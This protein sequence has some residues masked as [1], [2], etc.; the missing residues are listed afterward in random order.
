MTTSTALTEQ[1]ARS[2]RRPRRTDGPPPEEGSPVGVITIPKIGLQAVIVEGIDRADLKKG[3]G[4]YPGTPL[5]GQAGNAAIAGHRTTYGA[6]FNRIDEL[7]PGDEIERHHAAGQLPVPGPSRAGGVDGSPP[8][9][10]QA[11]W[12][13]KPSQT[14]V[15]D[16]STENLLTLTACHPKYSASER[17]I[18]QAEL[19]TPTAAAAPKPRSPTVETACPAAPLDQGLGGDSSALPVAL[20]FLAGA[21]AIGALAWFIG[22]RWKRWPVY[23]VATPLILVCV[24]S[25]TSTSTA[26]SRRCDRA[27]VSRPS[28]RGRQVAW[29]S[30]DRRWPAACVGD[31]SSHARA[32]TRPRR[33]PTTSTSTSTTAAPGVPDG[34]VATPMKALTVGQCFVIPIDDAPADGRAVWVVD[35]AQPH[36]HEIYDIVDYAG[37]TVKGDD[38]PG[39]DGGTGLVGAELP[40]AVRGVR[41]HPVDP[42]VARDPG[43]VAVDG[44][45]APRGPV[46]DLYGLPAVRGTGHRL[47]T[48][49]E[50]VISDRGS[51]CDAAR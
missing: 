48:R 50:D 19:A 1:L 38:Y 7:I 6:P 4:H 47:P 45:V 10:N 8:D 16:P 5:P 51:G 27:T 15:L 35:C 21:L 34:A 24:W 12:A 23:L 46:G 9:P 26:T 42:V 31:R 29:R 17:I 30:R 11:W 3:P 14:E 44:V 28:W 32:A 25:A 33:R 37:P 13:V 40:R 41:R 36:T 2:I 18:V 39:V 22:R 49:D 20:A 43:V